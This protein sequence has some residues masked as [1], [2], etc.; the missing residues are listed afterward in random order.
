M[1]K[2]KLPRPRAGVF[3]TR[4]YQPGRPLEEVLAEYGLD[5]AVKLASNENLFGV[6]PKA[7]AAM[8]EACDR[9]A[10]Y[11][12][13][14]GVHLC[15]KVAEIT[16]VEEASVLLGNGTVELIYDLLRAYVDPGDE[17][18]MGAPSFSAYP[19][20][21]R[22]MGGVAVE[23]PCDEEQGLDLSGM[24]AAVTERSKIVFL[25]N[26]NNPTGTLFSADALEA[27]L[28]G[29]PAGVLVV[30]DEAYH[31]WVVHPEYPDSMALLRGGEPVVVLRSLSKS[32]GIAGVRIGYGVA[33]AEVAA[34]V[35]QVQVPFHCSVP[36][37]AAALAGL[38]DQDFVEGCRRK[39]E[40]S[41]RAFEGE[42]RARGVEYIPSFANFVMLRPPLPPRQ[43]SEGL[44]RRGF[45]V[46]PGEDLGAP[47]WLRVT[48]G[49]DELMN[50]FL[51]AYQEACDELAGES[52]RSNGA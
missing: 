3:S 4:I 33:P 10:Y 15:R 52:A 45:I 17:V 9:V 35:R 39:L 8:H 44:L 13:T 1:K 20:A 42:L 21:T 46:R 38:D 26:P 2:P 7:V 22:L 11:P 19:I 12:D 41:R 47:G 28:G 36:A 14:N 23:V 40:A 27:F 50:R 25:P 32:L 49:P 29:L 34:A 30:L 6:S 37:Q 16:G 43:V 51:I 18:V 24:A 48:I 31:D 5:S